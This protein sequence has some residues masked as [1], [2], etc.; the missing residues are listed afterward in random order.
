MARSVL[1]RRRLL[2]SAAAVI[3]AERLSGSPLAAEQQPHMQA[4]KDSLAAALA[5]LQQAT[6]DKGGHRAAAIKATQNA[7][8]HVEKGIRFDRRT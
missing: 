3:A 7:I 8:D 5:H 6:A 4:A 2:G 1:S